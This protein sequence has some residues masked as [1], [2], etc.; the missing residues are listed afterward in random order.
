MKS[1]VYLLT[2]ENRKKADIL[3]YLYI[4]SKAECTIVDGKIIDKFGKEYWSSCIQAEFKDAKKSEKPSVTILFECESGINDIISKE[5]QIMRSHCARDSPIYF[6]RVYPNKGFGAKGEF[7]DK[8]KAKMKSS[9]YMNRADFRPWKSSR[10]K[11]SDWLNCEK[12]YEI[13]ESN[14]N[15]ESYNGKF[16][17]RRLI[18]ISGINIS[19]S[20]AKSILKWFDSGWSPKDDPEYIK[21]KMLYK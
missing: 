20:T 19:S 5:S 21:F 6:N 15:C 2:F 4:G 3:P 12:L 13:Y 11:H 7:T 14:K 17:W 16:G 1:I 10:A 8:V 18:S 9:N